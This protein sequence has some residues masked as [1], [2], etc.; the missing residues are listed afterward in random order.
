MCQRFAS[1]DR[2]VQ[3]TEG[4]KIIEDARARG[5]S[6]GGFTERLEEIES[7][8][9]TIYQVL[10]TINEPRSEPEPSLA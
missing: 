4:S 6:T 1:A 7:H 9:A 2:Q 5:H 3:N 10:A 8:A